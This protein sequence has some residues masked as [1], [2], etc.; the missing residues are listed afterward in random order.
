MDGTLTVNGPAVPSVTAGQPYWKS[1]ER[2]SRSSCWKSHSAVRSIPATSLHRVPYTLDTTAPAKK[3]KKN[4]G[5]TY[6]V[7]VPIYASYDSATDTVTLKPLAVHPADG[8]HGERRASVTA[9]S[10]PSNLASQ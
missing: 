5:S 3:K 9:R 4:H 7:R 1:Q 6:T 8:A 2:T 10:G